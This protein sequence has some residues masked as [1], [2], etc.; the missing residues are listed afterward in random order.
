VLGFIFLLIATIGILR[1]PDFYSRLHPMS[2]SDTL[3]VALCLAGVVVYEG[4]TL[5]SLKLVLIGA[6]IWLANPTAAHA[7][8][9]AAYRAGLK[10]WLG[11]GEE[12]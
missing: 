11:K 12:R 5:V 7:L 10:P 4:F 6:F 2:K 3:G 9:R 1:L 8:S